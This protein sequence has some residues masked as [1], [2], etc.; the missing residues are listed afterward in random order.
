MRKTTQLVA[1][2]AMTMALLA[3]PLRAAADVV[4]DWNAIAVAAT[5]TTQNP[6]IQARLLAITQLAVFEAV[7]ATAPRYEPYLGSII[8]PA[9]ASAEAAA[10]AAAHGVLKHYL[11]GSAATLDAAR[12]ASL[13]AIA[14]GPGKSGGIS[15]GEAAAAAMILARINDGSSPPAFSMPASTDPGVWQLTPGCPPLGGVFLHWRDVTPFGIDDATG[16][17]SGP[18]P[19]LTSNRYTRDYDEVKRVGRI[20]SLERPQDR[21]DVAR[22]YAAS[23]PSYV[24]NLA[25]RQVSAQQARSLPHNARA[26]ALLNMAIN[27]SLIVSFATKYHYNF[28]RPET[29]I[30]GGELDGNARTEADATWTPLIV[31]PCFPGYGSNHAAGSYSGATILRQI[32]GAAGH[33]ISISN[34]AVPGVVIEYTAFRRITADIDDARVYG[35]IHFRFDQVG[36][37]RVGS[38]V[39]H[40]IFA[41]KLRASAASNGRD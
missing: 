29:A 14:D 11:P 32:Y 9:G 30:R 6:F 5:A 33:Q 2:A 26:F 19:R 17:I 3:S 23:S 36:G 31:T 39:A 7:N 4:L 40:Q 16:F 8:A 20:D 25:A 27:D 35:G 24:M 28:W 12:V 1:A 15:T 22:L 13:A 41:H 21:T 34:P 18:P 37:A 38:E 10:V